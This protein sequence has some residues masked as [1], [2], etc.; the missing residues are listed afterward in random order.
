[1][2]I[3]DAC[4]GAGGKTLHLADITKDSAQILANDVE[5]RRLKE[6]TARSR[7]AGINNISA[8]IFQSR[9]KSIDYKK[10][11]E[12][13]DL[14]LVDAPCSGMGTLRRN[15]MKKWT[16]TPKL[17]LKLQSRQI[18]ILEFY[19]RFVRPGGALVYAT[20][21]IMPQENEAVAQHFL[22][23]NPS[24]S[25]DPI[26]PRLAEFTMAIPAL[27]GESHTMRLQPD[28]H[29]TDAFFVARMAKDF[30]I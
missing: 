19:G 5:P 10:Y 25:A 3:L 13:F 20:C 27:P 22:D 11:Y 6:V 7:R 24:F 30:N 1:M 17:L 12:Y 21:S 2:R 18:E 4:A 23:N 26:A 14:V 16:L 28:I 15:P 29:K 9:K 8:T